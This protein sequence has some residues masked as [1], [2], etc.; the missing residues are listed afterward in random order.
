[1]EMDWNPPKIESIYVSIYIHTQSYEY[2]ERGG[3]NVTWQDGGALVAG[4]GDRMVELSLSASLQTTP[5]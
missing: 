1:M 4:V 5:F 3:E 2:I